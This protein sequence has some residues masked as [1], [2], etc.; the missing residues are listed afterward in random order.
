M[1]DAIRRNGL[2]VVEQKGIT[3][4]PS[5]RTGAFEAGDMIHNVGLYDDIEN[6]YL[7]YYRCRPR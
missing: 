7:L 3:W 5:A 1:L 4:C 2:E 6:C